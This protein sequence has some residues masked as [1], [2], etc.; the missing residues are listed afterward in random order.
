MKTN[1]SERQI[2]SVS[3]L[4]RSVRH[5]IETQLPLLWVEGEISNFARPA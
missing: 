5:L 4:N 1:P 3:Q 2:F